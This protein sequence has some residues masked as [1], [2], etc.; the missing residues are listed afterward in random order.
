M[1]DD[2][3]QNCATKIRLTGGRLRASEAPRQLPAG[4]V[5]LA[6]TARAYD[7]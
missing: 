2:R 4:A 5:G 1:N 6:D 7:E 3:A